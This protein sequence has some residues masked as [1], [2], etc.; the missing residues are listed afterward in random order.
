MNSLLSKFKPVVAWFDSSAVESDS[1]DHIAWTRI[2][3]FILMHLAVFAVFWVGFSWFAFWVAVVLYVIRM[4]AIT[5]FYHR[6]F[7]HKNFKTSRVVQFIF[8]FIGASSAQRGPLWWASHHR[9]HHAK[10]DCPE[11]PHS[12]RHKGFWWSHTL[13]FLS[14]KN[15][16][17]KLDRVKDFSKYPELRWLDRFDIVAPF[18]LAL[19]LFIIGSVLEHVAPQLNTSG[20]QLLVWGFFVSTIALYHATYTINSL[21]HRFGTRRFE[22]SDDSRNNPLLAIITLGEGWHNNHHYYSGTVRQGFKWF[23]IDITFYILKMM[24]W[25]GLVWELKPIPSR[26][27]QQ[28]KGA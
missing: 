5:A 4:F 23:E 20:G 22:T 11:D 7:S 25:F 26:I 10:S 13:W 27:R 16:T 12:P 28:L 1:S 6:Y 9:Q 18:V 19:L 8:A 2:V 24:S 17:T 3:P 15:F 14:D 21:A